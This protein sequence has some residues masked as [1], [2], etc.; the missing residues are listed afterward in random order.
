MDSHPLQRVSPE[1]QLATK[2]STPE[3]TV[4]TERSQK[5]YLK[6]FN[7]KRKHIR[8]MTWTAARNHGDL[9]NVSIKPKEFFESTY[10]PR[11]NRATLN[12]L[13]LVNT[14]RMGE[15]H[16]GD[17]SRG[18]RRFVVSCQRQGNRFGH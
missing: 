1:P 8:N 15:G 17:F 13:V 9:P 4:I 12:H 16:C 5:F 11:R 6:L 3:G 18:V 7:F 2:I 14:E 10:D